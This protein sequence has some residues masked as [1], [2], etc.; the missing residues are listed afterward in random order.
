MDL[1]PLSEDYHVTPHPAPGDMAALAAQGVCLV[2]CNRPDGEVP[3]ELQASAMQAAA[4]AAGIGFVYNPVNGAAM[5]M[6]NVEEHAAAL[7][8]AEGPVVAYCASGMRAVVMWAYTQAGQIDTDTIIAA[9]NAA[10]FSLDGMRGQ[11]DAI[12]ARA[13]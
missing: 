13:D 1:R 2:I 4:E 9:G 8:A 7:E 10:G 6:D 5:T 3:V 11:I 12:A